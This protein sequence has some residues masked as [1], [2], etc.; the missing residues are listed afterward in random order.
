MIKGAD[1]GEGMTAGASRYLEAIFYIAAEEGTVRA[2]RLADWLGVSAPTVSEAL[3][4]LERDGLLQAGPGRVL[5]LTAS[6][7][8]AAAD[9]VR[10][11]RIAEVWLTD[12]LGFDW[13]A[14]DD[15][16]HRI[17][18]TLSDEV[19]ERLHESLGR[20]AVCPHGNAIPGEP[21]PSHRTE[22]L[23]SVPPGGK[24]RVVRISEVAEHEAPALLDVLYR[25]GLRPGRLVEVRE[26]GDKEL[27]VAG[28]DADEIPLG[29]AAAEAVWVEAVVSG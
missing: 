11:H 9:I 20:P 15:E 8:R 24:G 1:G 18:H 27:T 5:V 26:T 16:A 6:G 14:A 12:A 19:L 4:R 28:E 22:P 29:R 21:Q 7:Q 23:S 17:A 13:V 2:A 10:R 3:R 25:A